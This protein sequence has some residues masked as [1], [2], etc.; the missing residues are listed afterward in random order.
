MA[1]LWQ[2]TPEWT[3]TRHGNTGPAFLEYRTAGIRFAVE[4][5]PASLADILAKLYDARLEDEACGQLPDMAIGWVRRGDL[6]L[7][8]GAAQ[9]YPIEAES[10]SRYATK[11]RAAL[12]IAAQAAGLKSVPPLVEKR[13]LLGWRLSP[14]ARL[15][16]VDTS[17]SA[18]SNERS[19]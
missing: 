5:K 6:G 11:L 9:D 18:K 16:W 1:N 8:V 15:Q 14:S 7:A 12:E 19:I 17:L 10:I 4:L 3:V 13:R 2:S